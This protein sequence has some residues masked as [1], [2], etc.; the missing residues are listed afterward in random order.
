MAAK[1]LSKSAVDWAKFH[2]L[3]PAEETALLSALQGKQNGYLTRVNTLPAELPKIDFAKYKN[4]VPAFANTIANFEKAY[5]QV[6]VPYPSD[7][8]KVQEIE[9]AAKEQA[10]GNEA[11][12]KES[13]ERVKAAQAELAK[14]A[15][16]PPLEHL[17]PQEW[18]RYF[19]GSYQ[20]SKVQPFFPDPISPEDPNPND[21]D[22]EL[23]QYDWD[24]DIKTSP[25]EVEH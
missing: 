10:A 1:R 4:A 11:W 21:I 3:V 24:Y 13:A 16:V 22:K 18:M 12:S 6:K 7:G 19:P 23:E 2:S 14:W 25:H 20:D 15:M 5:G 9:A 17:T 8:G